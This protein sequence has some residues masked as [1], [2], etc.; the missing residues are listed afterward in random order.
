MKA[1]IFALSLLS[2][3]L[4]SSLYA[5]SDSSIVRKSAYHH[6]TYSDTLYLARL[7]HRSNMML[8]SGVGLCG[9]GSYLLYY[10]VTVY[11]TGPDP[12]STT[13]AAQASDINRNHSQGTVYLA[14]GGLAIAGGIA[15][16][17][18]GAMRKYD[19][20][21]RKRMMSLQGGLLPDGR[22]LLALKF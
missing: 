9:V 14:A 16:V 8:G 12:A 17:T 6:P 3:L 10:G 21:V 18:L 7:N 2:S 11:R 5:Q 20:K 15:L 1:F 22:M 13:P 4:G 19:F